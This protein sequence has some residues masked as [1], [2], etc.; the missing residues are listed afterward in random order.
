MKNNKAYTLVELLLAIAIFSIV[1]VSIVALMRSTSVSFRNESME[2]DLEKNSQILVN[3]VEEMLVDC[4]S[5]SGNSSKYTITSAN[6]SNPTVCYL[7]TSLQKVTSSGN[8][9]NI[10]Y[11]VDDTNYELLANNVSDFSITKNGDNTCTVKVGMRYNTSGDYTGKEFNYNTSKKVYFRNDVDGLVNSTLPNL[12]SSTGSG[13][14]A[15]QKECTIGRYEVVDIDA[16][17]DIISIVSW[18]P[19]GDD[20][21]TFIKEDSSNLDSNNGIKNPTLSASG[22]SMH[23]TTNNTCNTTTNVDYSGTLM[24]KKKINN[25]EKE[26]PIIIKCNKVSLV[27]GNGIIE[28]PLQSDSIN[29]TNEP[30][31]QK[32]YGGGGGLNSYIQIDGISI[33]DLDKYKSYYGN[34]KCTYKMEGFKDGSSVGDFN[35]GDVKSNIYSG[36]IGSNS[37]SFGSGFNNSKL[38]QFG[39]FYDFLDKGYLVIKFHN[40]DRPN[41]STACTDHKIEIK[42]TVTYPSG[43]GTAD[44]DETYRVYTSGSNLSAVSF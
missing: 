8:I 34:K 32:P 37:L 2:V 17:F 18:T 7:K 30:T 11:S 9:Y 39:L 14:N 33:G 44:T 42:V 40:G 10:E 16:K 4:K 12:N 19:D 3:Q 43:S 36:S 26:I 35:G 5:L 25:I 21:I 27:K 23:I 13:G 1:M 15:D 6:S 28:V 22:Y 38:S 29:N 31:T 24:V 41:S 20:F